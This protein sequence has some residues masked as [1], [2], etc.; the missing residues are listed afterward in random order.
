MTII[1]SRLLLPQWATLQLLWMMECSLLPLHILFF[2]TTP[3]STTCPVANPNTFLIQV[4]HSLFHFSTVNIIPHIL[5]LRHFATSAWLH[6]N[7]CSNRKREIW[8]SVKSMTLFAPWIGC[9]YQTLKLWSKYS[10]QFANTKS[11]FFFTVPKIPR[12]NIN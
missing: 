6:R 5:Q 8:T 3:V 9:H 7:S 11:L 10:G 12:R 1:V 4:F 2:Y